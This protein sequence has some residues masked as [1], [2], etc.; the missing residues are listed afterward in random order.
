LAS[1]KLLPVASSRCFVE[2]VDGA[3]PVSDDMRAV[4]ANGR[5]SLRE[6]VVFWHRSAR[7]AQPGHGADADADCPP[8]AAVMP[9]V[10]RMCEYRE[11]V[12]YALRPCIEGK[13]SVTLA[14]QSYELDAK[15]SSEIGVRRQSP[16]GACEANFRAAVAGTACNLLLV[17]QWFNTTAGGG[18]CPSTNPHVAFISSKLV[19]IMTQTLAV[20][21]AYEWARHAHPGA[22]GFVKARLDS[23]WCAPPPAAA[24]LPDTLVLNKITAEGADGPRWAGDLYAWASGD[25]APAYFESWRVW[26]TIAC[27]ALCMA[28]SGTAACHFVGLA[29][30]CT[31]ESPLSS[32]LCDHAGGSN[33]TAGNAARALGLAR[34]DWRQMERLPY[35]L[36]HAVNATHA[37]QRMG[38][39]V[40]LRELVALLD[41][42]RAATCPTCMPACLP[43]PKK[44]RRKAAPRAS[45]EKQCAYDY[46]SLH[47]QFAAQR[48]D[49]LALASGSAA[50][51]PS[52][53]GSDRSP[54]SLRL[55]RA[56]PR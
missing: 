21:R 28:G 8:V 12:D 50:A 1:T 43:K 27:S 39:P 54:A 16:F 11:I 29:R 38:R 31:G 10:A 9:G 53:L 14:L 42:R 13:S 4:L 26:R 24:R 47:C 37:R 3:L 18:P 15:T 33:A 48:R 46:Q 35:P 52:D 36:V 30:Q 49:A 44:A 40:P 32:W 20:G 41:K 45:R 56:G 2:E 5:L 19:R 34:P 55:R 22:A 23:A 25:V 7:G 51:R 17:R 6:Q